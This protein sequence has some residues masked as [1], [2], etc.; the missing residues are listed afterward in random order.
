MGCKVQIFL[1]KSKAFDILN[2]FTT[3]GVLLPKM[4]NLYSSV[5][6]DCLKQSP[7]ALPSGPEKGKQAGE[8]R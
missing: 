4:N 5:S 2:K 7:Q 1:F 8:R 3:L 6:C